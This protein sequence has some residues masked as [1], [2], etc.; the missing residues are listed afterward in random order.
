MKIVTTYSELPDDIKEAICEINALINVTAACVNP[1]TRD[2][3][4]GDAHLI[5]LHKLKRM[6]EITQELMMDNKE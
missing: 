5:A 2:G 6:S 3:F 4:I 1:E